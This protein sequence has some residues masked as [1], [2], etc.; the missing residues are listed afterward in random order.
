M[1]GTTA[2]SE[3]DLLGLIEACRTMLITCTNERVKVSASVLDDV[4]QVF[5]A[6]QVRSSNCSHC[7]I[8]AE[9]IAIGMALSAGSA[10]LVACASVARDGDGDAI[11]S[12]CGSCRELLRDH[13][14][15]YA[16]VADDRGQ[17]LCI[18]VAELLPW[19]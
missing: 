16:V 10:R 12:P 5:T 18:P 14:I 17:P 19:P 11:W 13:L 9:A 8:C 15:A 7:S 6:V 3:K 2:P 4:G 1:S